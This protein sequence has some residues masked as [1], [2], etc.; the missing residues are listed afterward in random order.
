M[1]DDES[2]ESEFSYALNSSVIRDRPGTAC[3]VSDQPQQNFITKKRKQRIKF[4]QQARAEKEKKA[5][6]HKQNEEEAFIRNSQEQLLRWD[7][8]R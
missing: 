7:K 1:T 2:L 8:F 5:R 6:I 4:Q 3:S